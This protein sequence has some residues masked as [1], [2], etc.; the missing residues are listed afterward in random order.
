MSSARSAQN[1]AARRTLSPGFTLVELL[2]VIAI[3]GVLV[4]LLLP[5]VQA[6]REAARRSSCSN[7]LR[8]LG[9][10]A[11]NY[12]SAAGELPPGYL[13][14]KD[15]TQP[16]AETDYY[17]N[18][19]QMTGV[20]TFLLPH[21]EAQALSNMF[22]SNLKLGVD[23]YDLPY[24]DASKT[25]SWEA[26]QAR[27]STL[28][29]PTAP[30]ETPSNAILSKAY[31]ILKAGIN[32]K[33]SS[34]GWVASETRI[35]LTHY[36]GIPGVWGQ[37]GPT[38]KFDLFDGRGPRPIDD[39]LVGVFGCRTKTRLGQVTDGTSNTLMFGEAPGSIGVSIPD[40]YVAGSFDGYTQAHAWS[41]WGTLPTA[42]GLNIGNENKDGAQFY[43]KWL[44]YGSL[45]TGGL[46]Q[47][48]YV[49]GS[50]RSLNQNTDLVAFQKLST[51]RGEDP[52]DPT[53][54]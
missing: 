27:I 21:M 28:L 7:N 23:N 53:T 3:I 19:Q 20:F 9:L 6:A 1:S 18:H 49:D 29:C 50:V 24:Y 25:S 42:F 16:E 31:G 46:V 54:L 4:A 26:S 17:G 41:G 43:S 45:H 52:I 5:A 15:F 39:E 32:F 36:M 33:M 10:A 2:V 22:R 37:F 35:G 14:G 48:C 30:S 40:D 8:Q 38:I 44:Y 34:W 13:A 11:L 51:M 12:E 47:F